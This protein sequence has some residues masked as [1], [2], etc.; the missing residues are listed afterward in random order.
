MTQTGLEFALLASASQ[1]AG[2]IGLHHRPGLVFSVLCHTVCS[3]WKML[4]PVS[5]FFCP[6]YN[7]NF[8]IIT[9]KEASALL[10]AGLD[11]SLNL[12]QCASLIVSSLLPMMRSWALLGQGQC[13]LWF[14][15]VWFWGRYL[16][17]WFLFV[18]VGVWPLVPNTC[19][20]VLS[21]WSPCRNRG[22]FEVR[23]EEVNCRRKL[24]QGFSSQ[25]RGKQAKQTSLKIKDG[26]Y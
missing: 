19:C 5:G 12:W 3:A 16:V 25:R 13:W 10:Q 7:V 8:R 26:F 20:F 17:G 4:L 23:Q 2:I 15:F 9:Y 1:V 18:G 21:E 22:H 11:I 6:S 24:V 14:V